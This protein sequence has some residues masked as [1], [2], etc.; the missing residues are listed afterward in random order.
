MK[1]VMMVVVAIGGLAACGRDGSDTAGR[2]LPPVTII[3]PD[4]ALHIGAQYSPD[5]KRLFWWHWERGAYNLWTADSALGGARSVGVMVGNVLPLLWSPDGASIAVPSS[6][7]GLLNVAL[8]S[9]TGEVRPLADVS[10]AVGTG[11][12]PDGDRFTYVTT[13]PTA[14]TAIL[15][16][17]ITSVRT[18][19]AK[20]LLPDETNAAIGR[21]A[22][23]GAHVVFMK[24]VNG[25]TSLWVADS[26]GRN[27]RP[28]TTDGFEA[29]PQGEWF[30]P[31][32]KMIAYMSRRTG[33]TDIWVAA[34]DGSGAR[35]LTRDV[36]ADYT[37]QW[38]PDGKA[39]AFISERGKQTDLW[40]I[41]SAG[42]EEVRITD[43]AAVEEFV[44]WLPG[45]RVAFLTGTPTGSVWSTDLASGRSTRLTDDSIVAGRFNLSPDGSRFIVMIERGGGTSDLAIVPTTGG[46][47]RIVVSGGASTDFSW[48]PDGNRFVFAST[49]NGSSDIWLYDLGV[50]S[51]RQL[52]NWPDEEYYPAWNGDGS[53]V[54]FVSSRSSKVS[55]V[56]RV[57]TAGGEPV[58]L[59]TAGGFTTITTLAGDSALYA[60]AVAKNGDF[61]TVKIAPDGTLL[62]LRRTA[63]SGPWL[64]MPGGDSLIVLD[65]APGE[66]DVAWIVPTDGSG[67]GVRLFADDGQPGG[68]SQDGT[69]VVYVKRT[70]SDGDVMLLDRKTGAVKQITSSPINEIGPE[71][72][73]DGK[74]VMY[75]QRRD[76]RRIAIADLSRVLTAKPAAR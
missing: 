74:T 25:R 42:G 75:R 60:G 17:V 30:S 1:R 58:R 52:T 47:P 24:L 22:P 44:G 14:G 5:G 61:H 68:L 10:Y 38:S 37:P 49:R 63:Y 50:D 31:D 12:H 62:P 2:S 23:D 36:R 18:G 65:R 55:D 19:G 6:K 67:G 11:W 26:S 7:T 48:S 69:Q 56:W 53:A 16:S 51:L 4:T 20:P 35:Q 21:W 9:A 13:V 57:P 29:P 66:V 59:T 27:A 39:I 70:G 54:Y 32:G 28:L 40:M 43:D 15:Q 46:T 76:I 72:T 64:V 73:P 3:S 41:P 45:G 34:I 33:T 8:V 71:I